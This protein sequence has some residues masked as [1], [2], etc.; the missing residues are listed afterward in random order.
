[1][2]SENEIVW[3]IRGAI[4]S[5]GLVSTILALQVKSVYV[6][7]HLCSD[8]VYAILFPQLLCIIYFKPCNTY[9]SIA[10]YIVGLFLR[11][12]GGE[13]LIGFDALIKYPFYDE[14]LGQLFPFRTFAMICSLM[15]LVLI[16]YLTRYL[17]LKEIIPMD[18]DILKC[19]KN[20][21]SIV[22]EH[23]APDDKQMTVFVNNSTAQ[24]RV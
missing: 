22:E 15:T 14:D 23:G 19:F 10:A 12:A 24:E 7:F 18:Y 11:V 3:V 2:A 13:K 5:V 21:S 17:F 6:L 20:Q 16:S 9:G 8:L 4:L 1:M